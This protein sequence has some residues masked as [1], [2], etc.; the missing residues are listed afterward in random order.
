[1]AITRTW[2]GAV[3]NDAGNPGNWSPSGAPQSGDTL[4]GKGTIDISGDVLHGDTLGGGEFQGWEGTINLSHHAVANVWVAVPPGLTANIDGTDTLNLT[5]Q[6]SAPYLV[7]VNLADHANL[8]GSFDLGT[9]VR[10]NITGGEDA[11]YHCTETDILRGASMIVDA[12]VV[13]SGKFILEQ[14]Q[15][16]YGPHQASLEFAGSVSRGQTIEVTGTQYGL[17]SQLKIDCPAD[18]HG[19]V[20]LHDASQIDLVGLAQSD[21]W[22]YKND[23][24]S[25]K[26]ACG[27]V[28]DT[29]RV[30]S[31][32]SSGSVHGLSVSKTAAGD[33]L[34]SPGT[35][36][37]GSLGLPTS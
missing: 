24:L 7:N 16:R 30:E 27:K 6:T 23:M 1:M 22:T 10:A 12:D 4:L 9:Y 2:T 11:K 28:L 36:F 20:D 37:H 33:L 17:V 14:G 19:T 13:G 25:I 35:D 21:S 15:Y 29:L 18:F 3:N 8:F 34:V 32:T 31:D 26:A 5:A